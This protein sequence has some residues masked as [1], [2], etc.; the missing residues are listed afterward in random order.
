[1]FGDVGPR[2]IPGTVRRDITALYNFYVD[3]E[4]VPA[5]AASTGPRSAERGNAAPP[6]A[7]RPP[8]PRFNGAALC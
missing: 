3:E 6:P 5:P 8:G 2:E 1:M 7:P 4:G